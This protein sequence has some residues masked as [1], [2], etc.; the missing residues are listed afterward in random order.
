[1]KIGILGTGHV[2][3]LLGAA[4]QQA[5]H[6]VT[7][8]ARAPLAAHP[9]LTVDTLAEAARGAEVVVNAITG[10]A[11]VEAITAMDQSLFEG[12]TVVDVTNAVTA[13]GGL[14]Y[15]DS[16]VAEQ[17]QKAL[18]RAKVVK[19]MNT[20]AMTVMVDPGSIAGSSVFVSGN[21]AGAKAQ[22]RD[23]LGDL[24]WPAD[25]VIDLGG[26]ETARGPEHYF[27][28]FVELA[29]AFKSPAFNLHVVR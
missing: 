22:T 11:A 14:A 12:K 8:G 4:W 10:A 25:A 9:D 26:I 13:T 16:S 2:A 29:T 27:L 28:L 5:G 21:D 17:L 24:G 7:L 19:T 6:Q 20:A 3:G 1:M 15:P 18:P 23:L